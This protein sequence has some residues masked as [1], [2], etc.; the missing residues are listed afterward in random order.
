MRNIYIAENAKGGGLYRYLLSEDGSVT[1]CDKTEMDYPMY[2]ELHD[3]KMYVLLDQAFPEDVSA[4]SVYDM[5]ETGALSA[6]I[7]KEPTLG[8]CACHL[9][10]YDDAVYAV[11]YL[12]G[13]VVKMLDVCRVHTGV[14]GPQKPRQNAPHTHYV[15]RTPDE[16]FTLV[17]DLGLDRI[18]VYDNDL[19][20]VARVVAPAGAGP[21][22]LIFSEDH[23]TCFCV[24][25]LSSTV[26]AYAYDNGTLTLLDTVSILP[27]GF[28]G[29]NTAAA[30]R[31][32]EG[33]VYAS[34]R[35]HNSIA[36]LSYQDG[37]LQ[38]LSLTDCGGKGP[39]D[40][41]IFGDI[42]VCTNEKSDNVTF[43]KVQKEKLQK[44]PHALTLKGPLCVI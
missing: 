43:F 30:I 34:N 13:S 39:R 23:K 37:K 11:N 6:C 40:F 5:E 21:R 9:A 36:C 29:T 31:V 38:L 15:C 3:G 44:L 41:N 18:F 14:C 24:N 17:T 10:V 28:A 2:M 19:N 12:S 16:K 26:S 22:H 27:E 42:L 8:V 1:F 35:G 25:E 7:F 4:L 32:H 33:L 20:E